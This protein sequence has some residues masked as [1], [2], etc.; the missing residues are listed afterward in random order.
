MAGFQL[1]DYRIV[2]AYVAGVTFLGSRFASRQRN[3][4]DFF[5]AGR[6]MRWFPMVLSVIATDF[7]AISF[8]GAPGYVVAH[9]IVIDAQVLTFF[10]VLPLS[11]YLFVRFFH[12]LE[13]IS[14]YEYLERRFSVAL[15]TACSL[16]F[17]CVRAGWMAPALYA[18]GLA[19]AEATSLPFWACV[20]IIGVLTTI[21]ATLGGMRAVIWT[22][23]VQF[24]VFIGAIAVV[25][26]TTVR[27]VPS[28]LAGIW[29]TAS[30][31]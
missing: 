5:L 27:A 19:L 2:A 20:A 31:E 21:Y 3:A 7:S 6:S 22:D 11:F 23:V 26:F 16:L 24:F 12:R 4:R 8:L 18:T 17:I 9:D 10:W 29:K 15:R 1:V 28:G 13:L 14:A 25:L 30:A